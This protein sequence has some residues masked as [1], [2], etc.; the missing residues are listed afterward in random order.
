MNSVIG[1]ASFFGNT[2]MYLYIEYKLKVTDGTVCIPLCQLASIS[3]RPSSHERG[4]T[5]MQTR[6]CFQAWNQNDLIPSSHRM[7]VSLRAQSYKSGGRMG[8]VA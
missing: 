1:N 6:S 2:N 3:H 7:K 5:K 4:K 8:G